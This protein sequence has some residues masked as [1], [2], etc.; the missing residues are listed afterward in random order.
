[1]T[2]FGLLLSMLLTAWASVFAKDKNPADYPLHVNVLSSAHETQFIYRGTDCT[3]T[4]YG[5]ITPPSALAFASHS[6]SRR[7]IRSRFFDLAFSLSI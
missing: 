5:E 7:E 6:S 2:R 3:S 4:G 1:M